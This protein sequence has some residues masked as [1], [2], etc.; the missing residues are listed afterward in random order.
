MFCVFFSTFGKHG[1]GIDGLAKILNT[2]LMENC[3]EIPLHFFA[4]NCTAT[5]TLPVILCHKLFRSNTMHAHGVHVV[6]VCTCECGLQCECGWG[7]SHF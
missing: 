7:L 6:Y 1:Y 5:V 2:C 3:M 4:E